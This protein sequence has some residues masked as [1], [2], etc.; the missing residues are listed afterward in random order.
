MEGDGGL[1]G[2]EAIRGRGGGWGC[3]AVQGGTNTTSGGKGGQARQWGSVGSGGQSCTKN[4]PYLGLCGS[5]CSYE[6]TYTTRNPQLFVV[7]TL[8]N[9]TNGRLDPRTGAHLAPASSLLE[10]NQTGTKSGDVSD[11]RGCLL[12]FPRCP[13]MSVDVSRMSAAEKT[14]VR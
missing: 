12:M 9:C 14:P 1:Q 3:V 7:F 4:G 10:P 13:R 6:G 8:R 2:G 5:K 11:V